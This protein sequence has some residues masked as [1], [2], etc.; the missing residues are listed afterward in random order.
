MSVASPSSSTVIKNWNTGQRQR[1]QKAL[2]G[3]QQVSGLLRDRRKSQ[4][5]DKNFMV[6]GNAIGTF[7]TQKLPHDTRNSLPAVLI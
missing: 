4:H 3:S 5:L 7:S 6:P 1:T 2:C